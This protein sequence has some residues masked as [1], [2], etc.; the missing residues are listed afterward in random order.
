VRKRK[1]VRW[2]RRREDS[3]FDLEAYLTRYHD[4][5]KEKGTGEHAEAEDYST[6][7]VSQGKT[8]EQNRD[9]KREESIL[10]RQVLA[11]RK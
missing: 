9:F 8:T 2:T 6:C 7:N 1:S 3:F 10:E 5:G 4:I 11:G